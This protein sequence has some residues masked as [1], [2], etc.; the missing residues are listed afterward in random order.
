MRSKIELSLAILLYPFQSFRFYNEDPFIEMTCDSNRKKYIQDEIKELVKEIYYELGRDFEIHSLDEIKL[1]LQKYYPFIFK[2]DIVSKQWVYSRYLNIIEKLSKSLITHRDGKISYKYWKNENDNGIFGPYDELQKIQIFNSL[3]RMMPLDIIVVT[4][5]LENDMKEPDQLNGF[6]S[7]ISLSDLQLEDVLVK[8]VAENHIHVGAGFNFTIAWTIMMNQFLSKDKSYIHKINGYFKYKKQNSINHVLGSGIIR[9]ILI[10]YLNE[11]RKGKLCKKIKFWEW[12]SSSI[13]DD[14][15]NTSPIE[16]FIKI[17]HNGE[18]VDDWV[19]NKV[20]GSKEEI[21]FEAF[22]EIWNI[23]IS[24]HRISIEKNSEDFIFDIFTDTKHIKTYGEN[25]FIFYCLEYMKN[26]KD[27]TMF[28]QLFFNYIRVRSNVFHTIVQG[29]NNIKGLDYFKIYY[30][31]AKNSIR[32]VNDKIFWK[33][34]LRTMFQDEFLKKLEVRI[35]MNKNF[36]RNLIDILAA[37]KEVI[38]EDYKKIG[39]NEFPQFGIVIHLLKKEDRDPSEKC[40]KMYNEQNENTIGELYFGELQEQYFEEIEQLISIR[41]E[42]PYLSEFLLGIDAASGENDTPISVFAPI[43]EKA[44]DSKSQKMLSRSSDGKIIKNKSLAFTFHAGEDFRHLLSGLRRIDEVIEHCKFHSGDRIGHGIALGADV[45]YWR[46]M[47]PVVTLPRGEYLDNLLWV[48]GTYASE[49]NYNPKVNIYLESH[50]YKHASDI[51]ESMNGINI[52]MLYEAYQKRFEKFN[53]TNIYKEIVLDENLCEHAEMFCKQVDRKYTSIWN[54]DKLKHTY[55]CKCYLEKVYEPIQVAVTDIDYEMILQVQKTV[56]EK[57]AKQG[58]VVEVNPTSNTVIGEMDTLFKHHA[59]IINNI[60]DIESNKIIL[61]INSDD[62][63][64][65]N[66]N[67]SNEIAYLYY[68]LLHKK[69]SREDALTWI[70]KLRGYGMDTSF[71]N[72]KI[73]HN[74]YYGYLEEVLS[75]LGY[76]KKI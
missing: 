40:W 10:L 41:N 61:N 35:S 70:D 20:V 62:P 16:D 11:H 18:N 48:W 46:E 23:F 1:L 36:R 72:N 76:E 37:Y 21:Y 57:V 50:I 60:G 55:H 27:D 22:E 8:G 65:F 42:V 52:H 14:N 31:N 73:N 34:F 69:V 54:A 49:K 4:Y 15:K 24:M 7:S 47:N 64:V 59:Y 5:L 66:T 30:A 58:I 56:H 19:H 74:Q 38:D 75:C 45:R 32:M 44:R 9:L 6:Y 25:I 29:G 43:Y 39:E 17:Y 28:A 63:T 13:E 67:I 2:K 53:V 71:I 26:K 33:T 12:F 51:Y 68:G 3:S